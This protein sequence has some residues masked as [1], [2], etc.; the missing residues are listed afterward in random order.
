MRRIL[1]LLLVI[2][3]FAFLCPAAAE[4]SESPGPDY[5]LVTGFIDTREIKT[6]NFDLRFSLNPLAF[7]LDQNL[8]MQGYADFLKDMCLKGTFSSSPEDGMID[9]QAT[10]YPSE[11]SSSGIQFR[12]YGVPAIFVLSSP[13]MGEETIFLN[14]PALMAFGNKSWS[15]LSLPLQYISLLHPFT[16]QLSFRGLSN[17]FEDLAGFS[18]EERTVSAETIA[19]IAD[20]WTSEMQSDL[21]LNEW[22]TAVSLTKQEETQPLLSD[23]EDLP[24]YLKNQVTQ[25]GNLKVEKEGSSVVWKNSLGDV[26]FRKTAKKN[27]SGWTLDLPVTRAGYKPY[28]SYEK[29]E[30]GK[31]YDFDFRAYYLAA[32]SAGKDLL[33][34]RTYGHG[35]PSVLPV[36]TDFDLDLF[37]LG[38]V[39]PNVGLSV[40]GGCRADGSLSVGVYKPLVED[41]ADPVEIA[42][43]EGVIQ[44]TDPLSMPLYKPGSWMYKRNIFSLNDESMSE[45]VKNV[46]EPLV[47]GAL[48][49]LT[50]VPVSFCQSLL[51]DLSDSGILGMVL[52]K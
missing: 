1:C 31:L 16:W 25:S 13:L 9:I 10:V 42:R 52:S 6:W 28:A 45:F 49:F 44:E 8:K 11:G 40:R 27:V 21:Y 24:S 37:L 23:F 26:L 34:F 20:S 46:T 51:D 43:V 5:S 7:P 36:D 12:V 30:N 14:A 32:D 4:G 3:L 15:H 29:T 38:E 18:D 48:G 22:L 35:L 2:M 17:T 41:G 33:S 39:F 47:R 19:Q 50:E